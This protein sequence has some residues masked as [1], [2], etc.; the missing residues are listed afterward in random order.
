MPI[1]VDCSLDELQE[2]AR[3]YLAIFTNTV[4]QYDESKEKQEENLQ[5]LTDITENHKNIIE[6]LDLKTQQY[7]LLIEKFNDEQTKRYEIIQQIKKLTKKSL[8]Y[9][10]DILNYQNKLNQLT[11]KQSKVK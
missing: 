10:E 3:N 5:H 11:K 6:K 4:R 9:N 1:I 8:Q 7:D 2:K